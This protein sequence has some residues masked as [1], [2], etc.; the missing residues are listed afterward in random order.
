MQGSFRL[1]ATSMNENKRFRELIE[2][3]IHHLRLQPCFDP[4]FEL[5]G[6]MR[7]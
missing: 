1:R 5:G 7:S 6:A 2:I 4:H 3:L